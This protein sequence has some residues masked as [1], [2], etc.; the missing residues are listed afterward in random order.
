MKKQWWKES[1]VYQIYPRSF[2]D[3]NGDGIG[4]LPGIESKLDYLR[5]LGV[6]VLWLSPI[7]DSP[8][9]DNGYDIRDYRKIM[10]EFG[11]IED[12]D[13]LLA[14]AHRKGLKIV[15]DLV[16]NHTSDEHEWF[17]KSRQIPKNE[18]R[19]R[20]YW[21][22][23]KN[24][25][26]PNNWESS[27]SGSAWKYDPQVG[28]YYLHL[29]AEKQPDLNWENEAVRK[30]V[31]KMMRWWLDKGVDGFRMDVI[32]AISKDL[33]FPDAEPLPGHTYAPPWKYTA[34]GPRVHE[35]LQEMNR[36]VLQNYDIMTVGETGGV[37]P[38][39]A[40]LYAGENRGELNMVF[41]FEHVGLGDRESENGKWNEL[42]VNP[43][44]FRGVMA[45]WQ[46]KLDGKAWNS[47]FLGNHDQPRSV[48]RFGDE[49]KFR[50]P[51]AKMLATMIFTMQG[52]PFVYQGEEI[53]MT[54][55]AF[56]SIDQYRDIET[57]NLYREFEKRGPEKQAEIMR[58]IQRK[59]RD[60]ARIPH[61]VERRAERRLHDGYP[62]DFTEP[63]LPHGQCEA[64]SRR[65]RFDPSL[66]S[67]AHRSAQTDALPDL[68]I[69]SSSEAKKSTPFLLPSQAGAGADPRPSQPGRRH[70]TLSPSGRL[71]RAVPADRQLRRCGER[72]PG[73]TPP[74]GSLCLP[75]P[76]NGPV[77]L[78]RKGGPG[79]T[80]APLFIRS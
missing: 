55:A 77:Y 38:E 12:F 24:G 42:P 69:L 19:D 25:A 7:Y 50:V 41:Q 75:P 51:S 58:C 36:E 17:R 26:E 29:F 21:R 14:T 31:Y 52:T 54:N 47:L 16:V 59:S 27:F 9:A 15:M 4:D 56:S 32:N 44:E 34:N 33:R 53:G 40:L 28:Q 37:T 76:V 80:G 23:G 45:R 43:A 6:D 57:L 49:G 70:G 5:N 10:A 2:C 63:Q 1:T 8:N 67:E 20:Y 60:N 13:R 30:G 68:R 39:D 11:T 35:F 48:S 22:A 61:A 46:T 78:K 3:S 64:G 62:L 18:Y 73:S 74:L 72:A 71:H 65:P 79:I 66:L